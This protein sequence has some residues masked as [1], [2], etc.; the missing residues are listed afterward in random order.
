MLSSCIFQHK[1]TTRLH[2]DVEIYIREASIPVPGDQTKYF[3]MLITA[4]L[5]HTYSSPLRI[6]RVA[7]TRL[8]K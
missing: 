5:Q 7:T 3:D 8:V 6:L 1:Q 4:Y 2:I